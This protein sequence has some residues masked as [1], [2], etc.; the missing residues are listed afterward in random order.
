LKRKIYLAGPMSGLPEFNY[1][2]FHAAAAKLRAMGHEVLNPAENPAPPCGTY[3]GYL[4]MGFAQLL[5][6]ECIVLLPGWSDSRG[7]LEERGLA[8]TLGMEVLQF[9][10]VGNPL[11]AVDLR[12]R[13]VVRVT[14][15]DWSAA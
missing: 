8:Q 7:A 12:C 14:T 15:T 13:E 2:A 11:Q 3:E 10:E 5:Q 6:C 4:R 1:P 9:V